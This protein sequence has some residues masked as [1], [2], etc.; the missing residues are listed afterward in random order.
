MVLMVFILIMIISTGV[1]I[2]PPLV[3]TSQISALNYW[4]YHYEPYYHGWSCTNPYYYYYPYYYRYD[5]YNHYGNY[6]YSNPNQY[7]RSSGR[8]GA[9]ARG[10]QQF[11]KQL[12][13]FSGWQRLQ[14]ASQT[15]NGNVST[16]N[17]NVGRR[18]SNISN[19]TSTQ[20]TSRQNNYL[21]Y[22]T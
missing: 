7:V 17:Y 10:K 5:C 14:S 8:R 18:I 3:E 19:T 13:L 12:L 11:E 1:V 21:I 15:A 9:P 22:D 20:K 16:T 6:Y 2:V 4:S